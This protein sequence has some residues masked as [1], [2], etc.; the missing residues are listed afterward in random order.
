MKSSKERKA[1]LGLVLLG[2]LT[3]L[4]SPAAAQ[5]ENAWVRLDGMT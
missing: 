3:L 5:V 1:V 4:A 2:A